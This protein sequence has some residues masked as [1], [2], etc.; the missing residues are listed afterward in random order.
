M[1]TPIRVIARRPAALGFGLAGVP[2]FEAADADAAASALAAISG[3]P[4]AGGVVLIEQSLYEALPRAL[5]RALARAGVP[6]LM[7]FPGPALDGAA[8]AP[9]AELLDILRRAIGYRLRLR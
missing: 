2:C 3:E 6:I 7:P 1:R 8:A 5:R 4:V 9:E